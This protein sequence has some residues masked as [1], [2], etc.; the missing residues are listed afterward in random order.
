MDWKVSDG[1]E[2]RIGS[3]SMLGCDQNI[4]LPQEII[5]HLQLMGLCALNRIGK[6]EATSI[7]S[8]GWN[9]AQNGRLEGLQDT[10]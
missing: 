3:N 2:V 7:W 4:F 8:Q 1:Y 10:H 9:L 6:E 5:D